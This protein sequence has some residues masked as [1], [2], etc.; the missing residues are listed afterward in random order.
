MMYIRDMKQCN[1]W[2]GHIMI[3]FHD[4]RR[5]EDQTIF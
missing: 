5:P 2:S 3:H 4:M 1:C